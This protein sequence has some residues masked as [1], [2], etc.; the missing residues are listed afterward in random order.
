MQK[1][2]ALICIAIGIVL[3]ISCNTIKNG[4]NLTL[5]S[6]TTGADQLSE[7]LPLLKDK[8]VGM[9]VNTTSIIGSKS[10]V[11]T[12]HTLGV[13]IKRVFGPEHGFR[14][15]ASNGAHVADEIDEKTGIPIVSLY[16]TKRKPSK[17]DMDALDIMIFDIQDVGCRFY[18]YINTLADIMEACAEENKELI[19]L[20]RPNPNGFVD[21]PILDMS[22]KSGIGKFPIP[23]THGMTIGEFA[24]MINGE[25]WL[26]NNLK[27]KIRVIALK[28]YKHSMDYTLPVSPSPNLNTQQSI[29]LYPSLCLFEGTIVSQGRG[30]YMPFTV[31]GSPRL[32]GLYPFSFTPKSIKGMS[33]TPLH[34]NE[35]CFGLDLRQYDMTA[36][37]KAGKINIQWMI[38]MYK[39]YP[40]KTKFFDKS[41]SKQ[42]GDIDKLAG[43]KL[44][45]IQI[46]EGK[47][48]AEIRQTWEP[49]LSNYKEMRKKYVLYP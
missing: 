7:Y 37:R 36:F 1:I 48:E 23:I 45:K 40:D 22:L 19:I 41:Y 30:T 24:Q 44:F 14:A 25:G 9:L 43:T 2:N 13:N 39:A 16:G 49:Q 32:K 35:E 15:N 6:I 42:M 10:I 47:S 11:D 3:S 4:Q 20:D 21:G 18:T 27:C 38:D 5:N 8:R 34:Q 33:E 17:T 29:L 28:N 46:V 12:L 31:L 26:P